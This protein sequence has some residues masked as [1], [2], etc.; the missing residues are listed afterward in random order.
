MKRGR[1][2][3]GEDP[4]SPVRG[5][6]GREELKI[7]IKKKAKGGA[8]GGGLDEGGQV[9]FDTSIS[10]ALKS[11]SYT[12]NIGSK[13]KWKNLKAISAQL[14]GEQASRLVDEPTC[15]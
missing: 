2:Q 4:T 8:G 7:H 6:S 10:Q 15:K 9:F 13:K 5:E 11:P 12:S 1:E 14:V 3:G